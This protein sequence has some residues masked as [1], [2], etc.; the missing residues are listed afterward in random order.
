M[1]KPKILVAGLA[2][3]SL[4]MG[5]GS[6]YIYR[7]SKPPEE[8]TETVRIAECTPSVSNLPYHVA[9]EMD[10]FSEEK[11]KI[12][13][14]TY[15]GDN[16]TLNAIADGE[17]D[18]ALA[19]LEELIYTRSGNL[20][21]D[22]GPMA[23]ACL[24]AKNNSFLLARETRESFS[25][26]ELK[27]KSIICGPPESIETV[28]LEELLRR[29][30]LSP[31]EN[32][33]LFT[34]IPQDLMVGALKSGTGNYVLLREPEASLSEAKGNARVVASLGEEIG[35]YPAVVCAVSTE[36]AAKHPL[37]VQRFTNAIY[38]A[39]IWIKYHNASETRDLCKKTFKKM[40]RDIYTK[41]INRYFENNTW[42]QNPLIPEEG[43]NQAMAMLSRA[44]EIPREIPY[45][46]MVNQSFAQRAVAD[47]NYIPEDKLPKKQFPD[48]LLERFRK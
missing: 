23:F 41:L 17:A 42:P 9:M 25:W 45:E 29:N 12:K 35:E 26:A 21:D 36:Y 11:L 27:G 16:A 19:G 44:R 3:L 18:I 40:D 5:L 4:I 28:I 34:N 46:R 7:W 15:S 10:F 24:A 20:T 13:T 22:S 8:R 33:T 1:F 39:Q 48:N 2:I 47:I 30:D 14:K 6:F 37:A 32:V 38:K 43:F 31:H